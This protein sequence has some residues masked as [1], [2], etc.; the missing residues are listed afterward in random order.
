LISSLALVLL[1]HLLV[2]I[3]EQDQVSQVT[4]YRFFDLHCIL[5][6]I[7]M[8]HL[9]KI[10]KVQQN[11]RVYFRCPTHLLVAFLSR[12]S[13]KFLLPFLEIRLSRKNLRKTAKCNEKK[14]F[15]FVAHSTLKGS[16]IL[17]QEELPFFVASRRLTEGLVNQSSFHFK[18]L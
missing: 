14:D 1:L 2:I 17:N 10:Y 16:F 7:S 13:S 12:T 5:S 3:K 11:R 8:N 15:G 6:E 18:S 9:R 4:L